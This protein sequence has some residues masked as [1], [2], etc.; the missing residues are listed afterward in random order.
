MS[1]LLK[2]FNRYNKKYFRNRLPA[3]RI[4]QSD[5]Y[6]SAGMCRRKQREIHLRAGLEGAELRKTLLHE[7]A[8]AATNV[9]H[10]ETW[11]KE[12]FRLVNLGAPLRRE[13]L[14]YINQPFTEHDMTVRMED[15][16]SELRDRSKWS[17][18]R[19]S[20]GYSYGLVDKYGVAVSPGARKILHKWRLAFLRGIRG[21]EVNQ[22]LRSSMPF[23][24]SVWPSDTS[25][26]VPI[27]IPPDDLYKFVQEKKEGAG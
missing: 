6:G 10:G 3:Y 16:G 23:R 20:E 13:V 26:M 8:H 15:L 5:L 12:M 14:G 24:K 27:K 9:S 19:R 25:Q 1:V 2:L 18:L 7:M 11:R 22:R 17:A 4:I 21:Y